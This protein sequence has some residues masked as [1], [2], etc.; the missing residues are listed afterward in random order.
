MGMS[1]KSGSY[2]EDLVAVIHSSL[3]KLVSGGEEVP[4]FR[5]GENIKA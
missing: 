5:L 2:F 4:L 1:L 3:Q